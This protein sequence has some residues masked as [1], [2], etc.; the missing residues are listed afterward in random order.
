[1]FDIDTKDG[2]V[3]HVKVSDPVEWHDEMLLS[4]VRGRID[5]QGTQGSWSDDGREFTMRSKP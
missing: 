2:V 4:A 3:T 5:E 1:M